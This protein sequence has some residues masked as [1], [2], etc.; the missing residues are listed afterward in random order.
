MEKL[1]KEILEKVGENP[2]SE[3]LIKTPRRASVA[4]EFLT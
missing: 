3:G 1:Y 2:K 4:M